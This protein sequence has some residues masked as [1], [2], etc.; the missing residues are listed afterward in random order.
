MFN[1]HSMGFNF[2]IKILFHKL[3]GNFNNQ[4]DLRKNINLIK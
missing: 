1:T 3:M 4:F 2:K